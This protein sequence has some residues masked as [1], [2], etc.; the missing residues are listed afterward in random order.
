MKILIIEDE[1]K[2][3]QSIFDYLKKE[4]NYQCEMAYTLCSGLEKMDMHEYDCVVLD[5]GLPDGNGLNLVKQMRKQKL[6]CG[7][8]IISAKSS[9]TD[10]VTGLD[11]GADDYLSK[12]FHLSELNARIMSIYRRRNLNEETEIQFNEIRVL[13]NERE[14][15]I[16]N[17][18]LNLT[19]KEFNI[20]LYFISNKNRVLT[21]ESILDHFLENEIESFGSYDF[22]YTH[23]KNLRHKIIEKGGKDYIRTVYGIGYKMSNE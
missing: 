4:E 16:N 18:L 13:P 12:P 3:A 10:K 1:K 7:I 6:S 11:L 9:L 17:I 22:I 19:P 14:V 15:Y 20:L 5:I 23:I 2:L 21:K 8:L